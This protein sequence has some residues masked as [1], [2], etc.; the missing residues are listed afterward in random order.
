MGAPPTVTGPIDGREPRLAGHPAAAAVMLRLA[1]GEAPLSFAACDWELVLDVAERERCA[2]LAWARSAA[3][4]RALAPPGVVRRWRA[5]AVEAQAHGERQLEAAAAITS[6]LDGARID[7]LVLKGAP[8]S[9]RLYHDSAVRGS[10][11]L[12]LFVPAAQRGAATSVFRGQGWRVIE[13]TAPWTETLSLEGDGGT[14]FME[15]H[16]SIA[17][18][19]L[20]HL[21]LP[22][23]TGTLKDIG[24]VALRVHDDEYL[25]GYLASHAAKHMPIALLYFVDLYTLWELMSPGDRTRALDAARRV[26]L[27]RYVEWALERAG[28][29]RRAAHGDEHALR[30]LGVTASGRRGPHALFRDIAL[31]ET[32]ADATRATAAWLFPPHLRTGVRPLVARWAQRLA[33]PWSGYLAPTSSIGR[34][35][36]KK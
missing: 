10:A 17:D 3:S 13:G 28:A 35:V 21:P 14:V 32:A 1:L 6:A 8:L 20:L 18:L 16:S 12:D 25:V 4:I 31:A 29:V 7:W 24:G 27:S 11:D 36:P 2:V 15:V 23:P 22:E 30:T 19:N 5:L 26:R 34:R 33:K 9:H